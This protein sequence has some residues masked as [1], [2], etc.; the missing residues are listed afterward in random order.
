M[1]MKYTLDKKVAL[2]SAVKRTLKNS[3]VF[4]SNRSARGNQVVHYNKEPR[5]QWKPFH[6]QVP[7]EEVLRSITDS[8]GKWHFIR[9]HNNA[10]METLPTADSISNMSGANHCNIM[11]ID[12]S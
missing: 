5:S 10:M 3:T 12:T 2:A 6:E 8:L 11:N 1:S 7:L 4:Q 9:H